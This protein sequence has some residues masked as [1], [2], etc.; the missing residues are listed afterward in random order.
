MNKFFNPEKESK[1][2]CHEVVIISIN[3][4]NNKYCNDLIKTGPYTILFLASSFQEFGRIR[5]IFP[6][7]WPCP[8]LA[9]ELNETAYK[10]RSIIVDLDSILWPENEDQNMWDASLL[11]ERGP[12]SSN[13]MLNLARMELFLTLISNPRRY[14]VIVDDEAFGLCM[15][16]SA[17]KHG[18]AVGW[19]SSLCYPSLIDRCVMVSSIIIDIYW[20][21]RRRLGIV[22]RFL[23]R[24]WQLVNFRR[25]RPLPINLLKDA[26]VLIVLWG[27]GKTFSSKDRLV[28]E[29][30]YGQ[31][32][33]LMDVEKIKKGYL[34]HPL[35]YV[36]SYKDILNNSLETSE[37]VAFIE[38]FI[39]WWAIL[40][41]IT[42]GL[43]FPKKLLKF[44]SSETDLSPLFRIE[45]SKD[46]R[47]SVCVEAYLMRYV[48][49]GL[50]RHLINPNVVLYPYEAQPWEKLLIRGMRKFLKS[51]VIA[52]VQHVLF[53]KNYLS[54]IPSKRSLAT[55]GFPDLILTAGYGY[56]KWFLEAGVAKEDILEIGALRYENKTFINTSEKTEYVLCCTGI[57][58]DEAIELA[59]KAVLAV[60]SLKIPVLVSFHPVT[61]AVFHKKIYDALAIYKEYRDINIRFTSRPIK[62]LIQKSIAV[63]YTSSAVCFESIQAGKVA[64]YVGRDF[65]VDYDKLPDD[66]AIRCRSV[67]DLEDLIM[68]VLNG[69]LV[70]PS[71]Q[72]LQPW[73]GEVRLPHL[74][75]KLMKKSRANQDS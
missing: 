30:N 54:L 8:I 22:F 51:V 10:L 38:D 21:L 39:P 31:L 73:L 53:S 66:I 61:D 55:G 15:L 56:S 32:P 25:S 16:R 62:D 40:P 12:F 65:N 29:Y 52:G 72:T 36:A 37:P 11:G 74:L 34:I 19:K 4:L 6:K 23:I 60:K 63:L 3:S 27:R 49:L 68:K 33:Y 46:R 18:V 17:E 57:E 45:A 28:K 47:L 71:K 67:N 70:I 44:T 42:V 69:S 20:I 14:L 26:E 50:A 7:E 5:R 1:S 64:I 24:K 35:T 58:L 9:K 75:Q 59:T 2:L 13:T 41:A 43:N 48:G